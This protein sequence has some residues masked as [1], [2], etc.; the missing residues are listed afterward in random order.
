MNTQKN[1]TSFLFS[2]TSAF[3]ATPLSQAVA[4]EAGGEFHGLEEVVVTAQKREQ[5]LQD[6]PMAI[7]AFSGEMVDK[8]GFSELADVGAH[9]AGLHWQNISPTK[10]RVYIRGLGSS[11]FDA[12]SDPSIAVFIDEVYMSRFASMSTE[13]L[14]VERV[15]VLKGPQGTLF[16]R[17][18]AGGAIHVIT[19][20]PSEEL[21]AKVKAGISNFNGFDL[22]GTVSGPLLDNT[23]RGRVSFSSRQ[24]DGYVRDNNQPENEPTSTDRVVIKGMVEI[25]LSAATTL[26]LTGDRSRTRDGMWQ[27]ENQIFPD[28]SLHI[29]QL[30]PPLRPGTATPDKFDENYNFNG[31][32]DVDSWG[33][34]GRLN[35]E[36]EWADFTS[37]VAYRDTDMSERTDFDASQFDALVREFGDTGDSLSAEF[38]LSSAQG[39]TLEW[40]AGLYYFTEDIRRTGALNLGVDNLFVFLTGG[41]PFRTQDVRNISTDSYALFGQATYPLGDQI[42]ITVGARY[43]YDDKE[44]DRVSST[45]GAVDPAVNPFVNGG[46]FTAAASDSWSSFDPTLSIDYQL[47]DDVLLYASYREGYKSGG[48]QT[49]PVVD[50]AIAEKVFDPEEIQSFEV[51]AKSTWFDNRFEANVAVFHNNYDSLQVFTVGTSATG[52]FSALIDNAAEATAEGVELDLAVALSSDFIVRA[53]Y[54]Y[55]DSKFDDFVKGSEDFSGVRTARSPENTLNISGDYSISLASGD[56]LSIY[57]TAAYTDDYKTDS[58]IPDPFDRLES[59]TVVDANISYET[60]D[61]AWRFSLWGKNLTDEEYRTHNIS[62]VPVPGVVVGSIDTWAKPLSYGVDVVWNYE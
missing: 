62:I 30:S 46:G 27:L 5:R 38:R 15:E 55:L 43:S 18:A 54:A 49:E 11:S 8:K 53:N 24:S 17:N 13:L 39:S 56:V 51:G 21:S 22:K 32:Q 31:F 14:D 52:A 9:T 19:Q 37:I 60:T 23:A 7:S 57:V 6:V 25:D 2:V 40:V 28:G 47:G 3:I 50:S 34:S 59:R 58:T 35:T 10:P 42:R 20:R 16:G 45:V 44:M 33:F 1:I 26:T 61:G 48:F 4:Q 36:M 41:A 12:G 29:P